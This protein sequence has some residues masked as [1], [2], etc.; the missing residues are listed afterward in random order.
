MDDAS[1]VCLEELS[2]VRLCLRHGAAGM[3]LFDLGSVEPEL[4]ENFVVMLAEAG[5]APD[6]GAGGDD[7][8]ALFYTGGTT[9][10]SKGVMLSHRNIVANALNTAQAFGGD[11][12]SV[13]V[14][15]APMFHAASR[16]NW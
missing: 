14:H 9:G 1:H 7:L 15:A 2:C 10:R 3:K 6:A 11:E 4:A 5:P 8:A 16:M 13:Y 12:D